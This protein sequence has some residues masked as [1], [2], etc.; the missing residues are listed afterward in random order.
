MLVCIT[1]FNAETHATEVLL[2]DQRAR[3]SSQRYFSLV[4][5]RFSQ[6]FFIKSPLMKNF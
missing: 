6:K 2:L 5:R 4:L 1:I 3:L